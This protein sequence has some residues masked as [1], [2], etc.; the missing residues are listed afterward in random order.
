LVDV[1]NNKRLQKI[2]DEI[3]NIRDD[4]RITINEI[5]ELIENN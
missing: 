4:K 2:V 1:E 3:K 5:I